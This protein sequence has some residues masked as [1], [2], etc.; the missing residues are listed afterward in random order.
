ME[1]IV[2][3]TDKTWPAFAAGFICTH[4]LPLN[5]ELPRLT[6][7]DREIG[8][9][10]N[11]VMYLLYYGMVTTTTAKAILRRFWIENVKIQAQYD[12]EDFL[13]INDPSQVYHICLDVV[14]N[15]LD[16]LN[17][18]RE[19]PKSI[20]ALIGKVMKVTKGRA[21]SDFVTRFINF[22]IL[23]YGCVNFRDNEEVSAFIE[24]LQS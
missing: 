3:K 19:Q 17:R 18:C 11:N 1:T 15:N 14:E 24:G 8:E 5:E 7:D 12:E 16:L 10:L 9:E 6:G 13:I 22:F 2:P 20:G 4:V 23:Y 21:D